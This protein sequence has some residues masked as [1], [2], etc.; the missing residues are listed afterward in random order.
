MSGSTTVAWAL[1]FQLVLVLRFVNDL[2]CGMVEFVIARDEAICCCNVQRFVFIQHLSLS[3]FFWKK[4]SNQK[5]LKR[6][7]IKAR[8]RRGS[9]KL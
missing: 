8:S 5:K 9:F 3:F 4:E 6:G 2:G 7:K 1:A